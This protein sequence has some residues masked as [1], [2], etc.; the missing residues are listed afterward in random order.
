MLEDYVGSR[1]Q[2]LRMAQSRKRAFE[3]ALGAARAGESS[4]K[5]DPTHVKVCDKAALLRY[6]SGSSTLYV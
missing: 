2:E 6:G 4:G 3:T 5:V 1:Q